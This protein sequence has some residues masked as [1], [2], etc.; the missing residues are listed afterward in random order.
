[1]TVCRDTGFSVL[2]RRA[3][4]LRTW[5]CVMS[6]V[7]LVA[8][9]VASAGAD[10]LVDESF[11][12]PV[13]SAPLRVGGS[14]VPCLTASTDTGQDNVAGCAAG[15][16][17]I[18]AG[19][20]V[21]GAGAL[22]LTDNGHDRSG[23]A[24]YRHIFPFTSGLRFT[25]TTFAYNGLRVP[26]YGAGD[27][28]SVF[29]TDGGVGTER[30]GAF[31]GSLGYAQKALDFDAT[32]PDIPGVPGGYLGLGIDEFGNYA[33]DREARGYGCADRVDRNIHPN[34]ISLRG[35]GV[36]GTDWYNGYCLLDRRP[37]P[38]PGVLDSP[39]ATSRFAPGVAHTFRVEVDPL[40]RPDGTP[41]PTAHVRVFADMGNAGTFVPVLDS[42][43][44]ADPPATFEF[45]FAAS[46]GLGTNI[47]EIRALHLETIAPLPRWTL[48]KTHPAPM[49]AGG[50][51]T[52]QLQ[53][54]LAADGG[55]AYEPVTAVDQLPEGMTVAA[56]PHGAGWDC[57]DTVVGDAAVRCTYAASLEQPIRPGTR[58]PLLAVPIALARDVADHVVNRATLTGTEIVTPVEAD[59][60]VDVVRVV[61]VELRKL[62]D[63]ARIAPGD[64]TRYT[65]IAANRG[66]GD[67]R[68]VVVSD[69]LPPGLAVVDA[70]SSTGSC[71][72]TQT[73][74]RCVLGTLAAGASG[75]VVVD[76][77][78]E[79]TAP[80]GT[81]TNAAVVTTSDPDADPAN[82]RA[83]APVEIV[84]PDDPAQPIS[85]ADVRLTVEKHTT[86]T[87]VRAGFPITYNIVVRNRGDAVAHDVRIVD[88]ASLPH[89]VRKLVARGRD[90]TTS[91]VTTTITCRLGDLRA[92]A[93]ASIS[94]ETAYPRPGL[95]VN[96]VTVSP[97][98]SPPARATVPVT[99][100][101]A[102]DLTKTVDRP[103]VRVG[104]HVR[105]RIRV[106]SL[107]PLPALGV[108]V[109][110]RLPRAL[111]LAAGPRTRRIVCW[112]LRGLTPGA[113][114]AFTVRAVAI[115]PTDGRVRSGAVATARNTAP[116]RATRAI[117]VRA[118]PEPS[119][120]G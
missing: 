28:I 83:T 62:A 20:D 30:P 32:V 56:A 110:S 106:R 114:R 31:G 35:R 74:V 109:C 69:Q 112:A 105:F 25:F 94:V 120:L 90:C 1:M 63:P 49:H 77:A 118:A 48:T 89:L 59:D 27:G 36:P 2:V 29:F 24:I 5:L 78:G 19:G 50:A 95:A 37:A 45:G 14:F 67:A 22:R 4:H 43:L 68:D 55:V 41:D 61:D 84:G 103:S 75:Q 15:Q 91:P 46:T 12:S 72:H 57:A 40:G 53:A 66:P 58:L 81:L 113:S 73:T 47:H 21:A 54:A 108:R 87:R 117:R 65:L 99:G 13:S 79:A 85:S 86:W 88:T 102:L 18:P 100:G 6:F 93:S 92:G 38:P 52:Y 17:S 101:A 111:R 8:A 23:F 76:A 3:P 82:D 39:D 71:S 33:N 42:P 11:S 44:G 98:A 60:P 116:A 70:R 104:G 64:P 9:G 26:G 51:G 96:V 34:Y 7:A 16:P 80:A 119:G 107:G 97:G 115:A 10:V